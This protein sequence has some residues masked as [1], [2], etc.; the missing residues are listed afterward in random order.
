MAWTPLFSIPFLFTHSDRK[1]NAACLWRSVPCNFKQ[2]EKVDCCYM[3]QI[4]WNICCVLLPKGDAFNLQVDRY[5]VRVQTCWL[6]C[7]SRI[8]WYIFDRE[9]CVRAYKRLSVAELHWKEDR[10]EKGRLSTCSIVVCLTCNLQL[11][12]LSFIHVSASCTLN[13]L[14]IY[15]HE[16]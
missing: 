8:I 1:F 3:Y 9:L 10:H 16:Q 15:A 14:V 6:L 12:L 7:C 11:L 2:K 4:R 5:S 13:N